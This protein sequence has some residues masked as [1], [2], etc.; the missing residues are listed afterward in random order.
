MFS[1][2]AAMAST[3]W[4]GTARHPARRRD[5]CRRPTHPDRVGH[6]AGHRRRSRRRARR[7]RSV[8]SRDRRHRGGAAAAAGRGRI[9]RR[10]RQGGA[11]RRTVGRG[12]PTG[13]DEP[14]RVRHRRRAIVSA[15]DAAV[16]GPP[17]CRSVAGHHGA[18]RRSVGRTPS[19]AARRR[20]VGQDRPAD[21]SDTDRGAH[22]RRISTHRRRRRRYRDPSGRRGGDRYQPR[23][24]S[25]IVRH[26]VEGNRPRRPRFDRRA[27]GR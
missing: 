5:R 14:V 10:G 6:A 16:D 21:R 22:A 7:V 9:A 18:P 3:R 23:G 11:G 15:V 13:R 17:R 1:G 4:C 12:T 27:G 20:P 8:R 25:G 19:C 2:S 24:P 26:V